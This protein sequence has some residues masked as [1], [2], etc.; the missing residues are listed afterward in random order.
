MNV[1][2]HTKVNPFGNS[3]IKPPNNGPKLN[4]IVPRTAVRL[5]SS[6]RLSVGKTSDTIAL[7]NP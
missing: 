1:S 5:N 6:A 7:H 2:E 4:P 3:E